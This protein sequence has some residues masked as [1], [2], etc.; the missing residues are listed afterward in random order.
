M[1]CRIRVI[2]DDMIPM[3]V[4]SSIAAGAARAP[5]ARKRA[6]TNPKESFMVEV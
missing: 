3:E 5:E 4:G 1:P 2:V 6:V